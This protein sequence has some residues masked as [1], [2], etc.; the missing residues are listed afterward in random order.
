VYSL[1]TGTTRACTGY[2]FLTFNGNT[3]SPIGNLGGAEKIQEDVNPFPR[4]TRLWF[5]AV[6]TTQIQDVLSE[7]LFNRP[8]RIYRSFLT[9]SFTNVATPEELFRG[10]IN[11]CDMELQNPQRGDFFQ[12]E[13]ESRLMRKSRAQYLNRETLWTFY[14]QSGDTFFDYLHLIPLT[15]ANWGSAGFSEYGG[16]TMAPPG[17]DHT[18]D[19]G[20]GRQIQ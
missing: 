8:V 5:A 20:R 16:G 7:N 17:G 3:Y 4:A 2:Q 9:D 14:N 13:V 15:K 6:S 10:F 1:S 11:T 12:I 19:P 18:T